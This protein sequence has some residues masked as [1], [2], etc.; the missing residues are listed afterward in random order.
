MVR[1]GPFEN[2]VRRVVAIELVV[3]RTWL[4]RRK[5]GGGFIDLPR[6]LFVRWATAASEDEASTQNKNN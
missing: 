2:L 5:V 4:R 1:S 6:W 3:R